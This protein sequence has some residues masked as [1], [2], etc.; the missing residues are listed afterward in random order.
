MC[1]YRIYLLVENFFAVGD[2]VLVLALVHVLG[3]LRP[4]PALVAYALVGAFRVVAIGVAL[5]RNLV[6]LVRVV[7]ALSPVQT[8]LGRGKRRG[9]GRRK[10]EKGR[11]KRK[12]NGEE[13]RGKTKGEEERGKGKSTKLC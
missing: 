12:R 11:G 9:R 10:W 5:A 2:A 13:E 8:R 4:F 6:A 7:L 3:A 1:H